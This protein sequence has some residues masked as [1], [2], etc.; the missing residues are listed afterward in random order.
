M[1]IRQIEENLEE[2]YSLKGIA[3]AYS[4]IAN[5]K[6][7][8]IRAEVERNR[9]FFA[10]I[11]KI[12]DN[13]KVLAFKKNLLPKKSKLRLAILITS[14]YRFYGSINSSLIKYFVGSTAELREVDKLIIG[15]A[16]IDYFKANRILLNYQ[17]VMLKTD[18]PDQVELH[19]LA[20]F[21]SNYNQVQVFHSQF[22]SLLRQDATFTDVSAVSKYMEEHVK[23]LK[24]KKEDVLKFIF[25]P[26]LPKIIRFFDTQILTLLL[27]ETFLE[28]ELSRTAS[29]FISMDSAETEANKFIKEMLGL[30]AYAK[31]SI[32]N[33]AI[34]ETFAT[35]SA[36]RK[37][38]Y[39]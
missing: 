23:E 33:N 17:P 30:K 20:Q 15:K 27:E 34:L 4:E 31:R 25:E 12:Y 28:S 7:K 1:T 9:I 29:R 32:I 36:L 13:L 2:G 22:K 3:Q 16:G 21:A 26:D 39:V 19:N 14:N 38:S 37:E 6:I 5:L 24:E 18:M 35:I 8:R 10:E 11:S